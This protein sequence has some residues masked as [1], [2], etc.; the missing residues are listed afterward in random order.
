MV[1]ILPTA[2]AHVESFH[3][4]LDAVARERRYLAFVEAPPVAALREFVRAIVAA[5]AIQVLALEGDIVVG[6]CDV[7]SR[8]MEGFRH[9]GALGM[10]VAASHRRRGV[11]EQL[12]KAALEQSRAAGLS[13]VEL[14]VFASN[15]AAIKLYKKLG[16]EHEGV[17]RSARHLDGAYD[18]VVLM[19]VVWEPSRKA[20]TDAPAG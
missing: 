19:A 17:K 3:R 11:G 4:C 6:W 15:Q 14:E 1:T 7:L 5:G 12:A 16:F 13:R 8:P 20:A 10:G 9:V 2:D 18:D